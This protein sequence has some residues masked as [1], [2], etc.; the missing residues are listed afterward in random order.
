M[1]ERCF[2]KIQKINCHN[3]NTIIC[4]SVDPKKQKTSQLPNFSKNLLEKMPQLEH[5]FCDNDE[6]RDFI[7]ELEDTEMAHAFEH[8]LLE[9]IAINDKSAK[10]ISATTEWNWQAGPRYYYWINI[11]YDKKDVLKKSLH[12][13]WQLF[14]SIMPK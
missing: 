11:N 12:Q 3:R 13:T 8:V 2:M 9:N 4:I 10:C 5:H 1:A 7:H 14:N 6:K